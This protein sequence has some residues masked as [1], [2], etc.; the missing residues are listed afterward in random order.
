MLTIDFDPRP[1]STPHA[2]H[3]DAVREEEGS[4]GKPL[5]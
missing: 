3:R 4:A 5:P 1:T 2:L